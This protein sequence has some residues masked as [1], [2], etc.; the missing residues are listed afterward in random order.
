MAHEW[1]RTPGRRHVV[2]NHDDEVLAFQERVPV[3]TVR[4]HELYNSCLA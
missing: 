1:C 4:G 2:L 3:N